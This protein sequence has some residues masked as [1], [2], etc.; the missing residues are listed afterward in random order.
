LRARLSFT[1]GIGIIGIASV[2]VNTR[3]RS[4]EN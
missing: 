2:N 4:G 3:G 1:A